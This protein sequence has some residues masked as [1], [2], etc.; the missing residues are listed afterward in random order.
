MNDEIE[1]TV[2]EFGDF[3]N[4]IDDG[5]LISVTVRKEE[6]GHDGEQ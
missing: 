1:M 6:E 2:E 4:S 3:I 5:V